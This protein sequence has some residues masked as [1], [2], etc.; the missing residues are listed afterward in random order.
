MASGCCGERS[1]IPQPGHQN[2]LARSHARPEREAPATID[3]SHVGPHLQGVELELSF[4]RRQNGVESLKPDAAP[5][6]QNLG[7]TYQRL[8]REA[9]ARNAFQRTLQLDPRN[10]IARERLGVK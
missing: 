3:H 2:E 7:L 9:D 10:A 8:R 6:W 5:A 4:G 1:E